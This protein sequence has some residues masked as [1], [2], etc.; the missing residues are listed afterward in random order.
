[1]KLPKALKIGGQIIQIDYSQEL[2]GHN[3]EAITGAGIIRI[4]KEIPRSQKEETLIHEIFH[5]LNTTL[6]EEFLGHC[7]LSSL[8]KQFYQ[9][10]RDNNLLKEENE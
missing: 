9:V 3:G 1:M 2:K 5:F 4:S 10:L 6:S 7:L 8:S